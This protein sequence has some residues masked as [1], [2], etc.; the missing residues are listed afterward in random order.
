MKLYSANLSPYASRVR[1]AIYAKGLDIEIAAPVGGGMKSA[2]YLALNPIGKVPALVTDDGTVIPE[3]ETILE[4]LEDAFPTPSLR[5]ASAED[6]AKARLLSRIGDIYLMSQGAG[7]FGQ[8]NP[9]TRDQAVVDAAF[10]KL[11]ESLGYL[12]VFMGPGP[13]AVGDR[14]TTAD[15]S[16][17][18]LMFFMGLFGQVF[19][20][21][22]LLSKHA[23][24][25]A[26]ALHLRGDPHV[27]TV[28]AEMQ[29][30]M[31]ARARG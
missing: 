15:C 25:A 11:D 3:S 31:A 2:E 20:K 30:A 17:A 18:P 14:L 22:D 27:K 1:L 9:A 5:P 21:S 8:M 23:K 7:L 19:G 24:V 4:Y 12:N 29:E 10:A 26:Y 28:Y 13:Y 6:K 16:L